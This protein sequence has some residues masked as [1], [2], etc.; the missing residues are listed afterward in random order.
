MRVRFSVLPHE[1]PRP[2][3]ALR[4]PPSAVVLRRSSRPG[5]FALRPCTR[6]GAHPPAA[7]L[8][9][10]APRVAAA[11][12]WIEV[13][14]WGARAQAVTPA[15]P[16]RL[17]SAV[18]RTPPSAKTRQPASVRSLGTALGGGAKPKRAASPG[19]SAVPVAKTARKSNEVNFP[20]PSTERKD[21][22]LR[23]S[24][25]LSL[26]YVSPSLPRPFSRSLALS[27]PPCALSPLLLRG[28][29]RKT[30]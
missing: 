24:F 19:P 28:P 18:K 21:S 27:R 5:A 25:S 26:P 22:V 8:P 12:V 2:H 17:S 1:E 23:L 6:P 14:D 15:S 3:A 29:E 16:P 9:A 4:S 30:F 7:P 20:P 10:P 11:R 13:H